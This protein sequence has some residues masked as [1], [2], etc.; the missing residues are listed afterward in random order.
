MDECEY[1]FIESNSHLNKNKNTITVLIGKNGQG[2]SRLLSAIT[3]SFQAFENNSV[4]QKD[5]GRFNR[6]VYKKPFESLLIEF[7]N[8]DRRSVITSNGKDVINTDQLVEFND[9]NNETLSNYSLFPSKIIAASNSPFDKFP[10]PEINREDVFFDKVG[11]YKY[12]GTKN[13][14]GE[15][16]V[17]VQLSR[18]IDSLFL[19]SQRSEEDIDRL[20]D[21]FLM[22]GY[23]PKI[24]VHYRYRPHI[25][26]I[27][28]QNT[29]ESVLDCL[30]EHVKTRFAIKANK[31]SKLHAEQI[32]EACRSL[33]NYKDAKYPEFE[34]DFT[35][36]G[37][38]KG[39][40]EIFRASAILRE[41]GLMMFGD[42]TLTLNNLMEKEISIR[43]ASSGEQCFL[44]LILG[45]ASEITDNSLIC[46]D[47]PEI[48]LHPE[49]QEQIV[50]VIENTFASYKGCHFIIATHS[51]QLIANI[52]S[53]NCFV[54]TLDDKKLHS[55]ELFMKRS[56][57]F[58]LAMLFKTPGFRNEYL[59]KECVKSLSILSRLEDLTVGE[60]KNIKELIQFESY[61]EDDD[62]VK[63]MIQIIK[64]A[65]KVKLP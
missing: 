60:A 14:V 23:K 47:E 52:S 58:Q 33:L 57:D 62:P 35:K 12:L 7:S 34:V 13:K 3:R 38:T 43:D 22:M 37:F 26:S 11:R 10:V 53:E 45:I 24:K 48:S 39:S 55:S 51:P 54:L 59:L 63:D 2:K 42:F 30:S 4:I 64:E 28:N 27:F 21:V 31:V 6:K 29:I 8:Y 19:A 41:I 50:E 40:F 44:S 32:L 65:L 1:N 18:V 36:G 15:H 16:S 49:W 25:R 61:L 46:I 20:V 9:S 56:S 17:A 5:R